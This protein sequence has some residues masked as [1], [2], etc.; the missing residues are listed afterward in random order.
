MKTISVI[1]PVYDVV[2]YVDKCLNSLVTQTHK[3]LEIIVVDDG[4]IDI[5]GARCDRWARIDH[6]VIAMHKR[7]GGLSDARNYGLEVATGDCI[8]FVDGDDWIEPDMYEL[9]LGGL[10]GHEADVSCCRFAYVY[11]DGKREPIGSDHRIRNYEGI[12][13]LKEYLWGKTLD[14]FVCNKLY[15]ANC[16]INENHGGHHLR[17]IKGIQGEDNPFNATVMAKANRV[18]VAGEAKYNYLQRTSGSITGQGVSQKRIESVLWWDTMRTRCHDIYPELEI[19]ALRRQ[20]LFYIGL[21][22]QLI[23]SQKCSTIKE[24]IRQFLCDHRAV[25]LKSDICEIELKTATFLII[26][27][28]HLYMLIMRLYKTVIGEARL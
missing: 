9:L 13:C 2:D 25:I 18:V 27:F 20:A 16:M 28:P 22:N 19:Y 11:E 4:S 23:L 8:G 12:D 5:S 3:E 6:R 14:P 15:R 24:K 10:E 21:Y 17:F 1:V 7:N 26:H